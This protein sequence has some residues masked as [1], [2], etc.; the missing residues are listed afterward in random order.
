M[1]Q[2]LIARLQQLYQYNTS[3]ATI[4]WEDPTPKR[5]QDIYGKLE[6][7][8]KCIFLSEGRLLIGEV[9]TLN[10]RQNVSVHKV[11]E[12]LLQNDNFLRI[13]AVHP[14]LL[15]RMKANFPPFLSPIEI[16]TTALFH[17]AQAGNFVSFYIVKEENLKEVISNLKNNDRIITLKN[18][19]F[20]NFDYY[21]NGIVT[22]MTDS[23]GLFNVKGKTLQNVL[24]IHREAANPDAKRRSINVNY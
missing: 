8:S 18:S 22:A 21:R 17:D 14:E 1:K 3:T 24:K 6:T 23:E 12:T 19:V 10:T 16:D 2:I 15:S 9:Q 20:K 4:L 13:H 5:W 7:G 11:G